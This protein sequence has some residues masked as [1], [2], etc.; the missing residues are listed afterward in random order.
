MKNPKQVRLENGSETAPKIHPQSL[1]IQD[2]CPS[3]SRRGLQQRTSL[4]VSLPGIQSCASWQVGDWAAYLYTMLNHHRHNIAL[5]VFPALES[6]SCLIELAEAVAVAEGHKSRNEEM[7]GEKLGVASPSLAGGFGY[8]P[9]EAFLFCCYAVY[10]VRHALL[11]HLF[12]KGDDLGDVYLAE[13][14]ALCEAILHYE[15][16]VTELAA[17]DQP[18]SM[19]QSL[20]IRARAHHIR[21]TFSMPLANA[22]NAAA[23]ERINAEKALAV[24]ES[25]VP[26]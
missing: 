25:G 2:T 22:R 20:A 18:H 7:P 15:S 4:E 17:C 19:L 13:A 23:L 9:F 26:A 1:P 21:V 14:L 24:E 10:N 3:H 5:R 6:D 16:V 11:K 12:E 8:G